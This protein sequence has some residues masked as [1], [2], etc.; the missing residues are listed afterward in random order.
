M[1][2]DYPKVKLVGQSLI[3][4][5]VSILVFI[6]VYNDR[7]KKY[8]N[9][10]WNE[11]KYN[12]IFI[13][14]AGFADS[15]D[16]DTY[17]DKVQTTFNKYMN[18]NLGGV[19]NKLLAPFMLLI[20]G[21]I[22]II[23]NIGKVLNTFREAIAVLR[24][25][26]QAFIGNTI[27][28]LSNSYGTMV[29]LREKMKHIIKRQVAM[30]EIL[31]QFLAAIPFL[32]YSLSRGPLPRFAIWIGQY[33]GLLIG[34]LIVCLLCAFGDFF[35]R[36]FAC[37]I[38]AICFSEDS[39][40]GYGKYNK[41]IGDIKIGDKLDDNTIVTGKIYIKGTENNPFAMYKLDDNCILT[42]SHLVYKNG[43]KRV[44]DL[45]I[46]MEYIHTNLVCLIT[47]NNI[48][49]TNKYIFKDYMETNDEHIIC[50]QMDTVKQYL[51]YRNIETRVKVDSERPLCNAGFDYN[52]MKELINNENNEIYGWI[53]I[54]DNNIVWYKYDDM[55][56]SANQLIYENGKWMRVYESINGVKIDNDSN[57]L[58]NVISING[59]IVCN[60]NIMRDF[61]ET[62]NED[63]QE[64]LLR[65][66]DKYHQQKSI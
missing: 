16:G 9:D 59:S 7:I 42:G 1:L 3:I 62:H 61:M 24:V 10:N 64:E 32:I 48:I 45:G 17:G 21:I 5:V 26:F 49:P 50:R 39:I 55:I 37:P 29:Y 66:L 15:V 25:M 46:K 4:I 2:D 13:P 11:I 47:N 19:M 63:V 38:C 52:T 27:D 33:L 56:L 44:K 36:I 12:P 60:G 20:E 57:K 53:E 40:V 30:M 23:K 43:W 6:L 58:Y 28:K 18:V 14:L 51:N 34:I 8:V 65:Q 31:K 35:T 41:K 54:E 22:K